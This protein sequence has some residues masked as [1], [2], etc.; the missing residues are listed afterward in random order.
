MVGDSAEISRRGSK[1][2]L[3]EWSPEN[4]QKSLLRQIIR[5]GAIAAQ[6]AQI[7]PHARLMATDELLKFQRCFAG[8]GQFGIDARQFN[9]VAND[10]F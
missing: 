6:S 7:S 4:G 3:F 10:F 9:S 1:T 5:Q 2:D 8:R